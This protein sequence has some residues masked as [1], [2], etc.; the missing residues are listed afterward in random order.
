[1]KKHDLLPLLLAGLLGVP[2]CELFGL[3]DAELEINVPR[4]TIDAV[5]VPLQSL[6]VR[7]PEGKTVKQWLGAPPSPINLLD[8]DPRL[9]KYQRAIRRL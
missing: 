2:G 3:D 9:E 7:V 1:M 6:P 5:D 4:Y 8:A